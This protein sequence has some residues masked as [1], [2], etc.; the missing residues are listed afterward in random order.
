MA[1]RTEDQAC[2]H[3]FG[4][5]LRLQGDFFLLFLG[6]IDEVV[7]F[8]SYQERDGGLVEAAALTVPFLDGV[9]CRFAGQVKHEE[10]GDGVVADQWQHVD[11]FALSTQIPD[12]ESDLG[13]SNRNGLLHEIDT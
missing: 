7:I 11:E 12:G 10:D 8:R 13:V 6:E 2:L 5:S 9:E 1:G 3:G 4:E